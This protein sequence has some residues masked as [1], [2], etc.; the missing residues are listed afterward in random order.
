[1]LTVILVSLAVCTDAFAAACACGVQ[2]VKIRLMPA[3]IISLTGAVILGAAFFMS[4][5]IGRMIPGSLCGSIAA[6][7]LILTGMKNLSD[8]CSYPDDCKC[9]S[10]T[11][12]E[13][14]V[15]AAALSADSLGVGTGA[16]LDMSSH[17]KAAA[18]IICLLLG[19]VSIFLG[20]TAGRIFSKR[21]SR[22]HAA[23]MSSSVLFVLAVI[24]CV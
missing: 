14:F 15:T 10:L 16:G 3:F 9:T 21:L 11:L 23:L 24:K 13:S 4:G 18:C 17:D 20:Q 5:A 8:A 2:G 22:Y 1:M 6:A 12:S 7:L 19:L